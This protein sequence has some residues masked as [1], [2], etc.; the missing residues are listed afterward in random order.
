MTIYE[1]PCRD[2]TFVLEELLDAPGVLG[3][4]EPFRD[5][6]AATIGQIVSEA[7]RFAKEVLLPLNAVGDIEGCVY[8]DGGVSTPAGF[9]AAYRAFQAGGWPSLACDPAHGGQ[10]LPGLL[11]AVLFEQL[12]ACNHAWTMYPALLHGAYRTLCANGSPELQREFLLKL[13]SGEWLSTMCLTE[14]HAGSD[15]GLLKTR[16]EPQ[17]DGSFRLTGTKIFIS[18]GEQDMTPNIIHMVLA[19]LP[20]APAGNRGISLFLVPKLLDHG[21]AT[22]RPNALRCEGIEHKMG[23]RGSATCVMTFDGATGWLVGEPHRGLG[24]MFV[25]MNAARL[26]VGM[27]GLGLA[28]ISHQN[29]LAYARERRQ[30]KAVPRPHEAGAADPIIHHA[31]VRRMLLTQKA[32]IE[33][34]RALAYWI[35]LLL[36]LSE[37]HAEAQM[38]EEC[39]GLVSLL[40]PVIKAFMTET[41]FQGSS[42][43]VQVYGGHG[44][45][46]DS[47]VDQFVRDS[48]VTMIYEGTNEIQAIDLLQRKV[49]ADGGRRLEKLLAT[50]DAEAQ[51]SMQSV[52]AREFAGRLAEMTGLLRRATAQ[53]AQRA[54]DDPEAPYRVADEYLHLVAHCMLA[55]FWCMAARVA[56][57]KAASGDRYYAQK[58][59]TAKYYFTYLAPE[60]AR[61]AAIIDADEHPLG[62]E[63]I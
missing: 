1:P 51:R 24:A 46:R 8:R 32:L 54:Q 59:A 35:G 15:L 12:A 49:L 11:N 10:G 52:H 6:D 4:L 28:E 7:G 20:D 21:T 22:E 14:P 44:Y 18:G 17:P 37:H 60:A 57:S 48:R 31:A 55:H 45:I 43:T 9:P 34:G 53:I 30:L 27:S 36:D 29:A 41:A 19:R 42:L 62:R 33:G 25:M 38:R 63:I 5:L 56:G 13:V 2:I 40:T 16:A 3:G 47:G 39:E 23:I 26:H 50:V 58:L 61:C